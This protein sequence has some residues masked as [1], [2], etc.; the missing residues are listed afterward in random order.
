MSLAIKLQASTKE[1][2]G[3]SATKSIRKAG[4]LPAIIFGGKHKEVMVS[5][6]LGEFVKEY[7]KG[8]IQSRLL[9]VELD[10]ATITTIPR[11]IQL[12]PITDVPIHV[13][14]QEVSHDTVIKVA[15]HVKVINED[16]APGIKI[17]GVLNVVSRTILVHCHPAQIPTNILVDITGMEIGK[18]LHIGDISL[19]EGVIPVDK[20]NFTVVSISGR[21]SE[22]EGPQAGAVEGTAT[23]AKA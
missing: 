8:N 16:K 5:F 20:S 22:T 9:E 4:R 15:V 13:D 18:N 1:K 2:A 11:A 3:K 23:E 12:D 19:P 10:N 21:A 7:S 6:A 14:L 17:G